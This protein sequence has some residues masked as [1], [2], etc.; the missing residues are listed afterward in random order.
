M[1]AELFRNVEMKANDAGVGIQFDYIQT[2][3]VG[4]G[5]YVDMYNLYISTAG[6]ADFVRSFLDGVHFPR[7]WADYTAEGYKVQFVEPVQDGEWL[8]FADSSWD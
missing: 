2:R 3:N 6:L 1:Y 4:N 5:E 8:S 7:T